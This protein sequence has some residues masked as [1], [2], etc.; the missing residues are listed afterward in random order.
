MDRSKD[1]IALL[2]TVAFPGSIHS[3]GI[4]LSSV[5]RGEGDHRQPGPTKRGTDLSRRGMIQC[6]QFDRADNKCDHFGDH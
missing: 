5:T 4:E 3:P 6:T 2:A 1:W